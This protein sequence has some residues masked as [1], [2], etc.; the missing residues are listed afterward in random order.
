MEDIK[1]LPD[2]TLVQRIKENAC[3]E[4]FN[5]LSFRHSNLFYKICQ[6]YIKALTNLGYCQTDIFDEKDV[7]IFEAILKF[8][9]QKGARFSTWLGNYTRYFCLNK[10]NHAKTMPEI[11]TEEEMEITFNEA[12][13]QEFEG[14][15]PQVD[16]YTIMQALE[17]AQDNRI[18]DIF[19]LRYDPDAR[20]KRTW[21]K[22]AHQLG[23]TVQTTIQL[24]KK[25]LKL[26]QEEIAT[27]NLDVFQ[28]S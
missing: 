21:A 10:I 19:K 4:S 14:R 26:L 18:T 15:N 8:N 23:L 3:C 22:I 24:H 20:K 28:S 5:E 13:I 6:N 11:G 1:G 9:P 7:V 16:F 17:S 2:I 27:K 12:S 25:G